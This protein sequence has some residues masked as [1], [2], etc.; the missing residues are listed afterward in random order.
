MKLNLLVGGQYMP[1]RE[2]NNEQLRIYCKQALENFEYWTR[3]LIHEKL[4]VN[5]ISYLDYRNPNGDNLIKKCIRED[6][7]ERMS[8]NPGRYSR[9]VDAFLMNDIISVLCNPT[10]YQ[11]YFQDA[12]NVA[13]PEGLEEARTFLNRLIIPRNHLSH[14][15]P[16]SIRQA[17]QILCYTNDVIDS[18][19]D[20][21]LKENSSVEYNVPQ[22]IRITDSFGNERYRDS[23]IDAKGAN[24]VVC[25][26]D[27]NSSNYLRPGDKFRIDIQIDPTFNKDEYDIVWFIA[28]FKTEEFNSKPYLFFEV[29]NSHVSERLVILCTITSNKTWHKYKNIDDSLVICLKVL[30]PL[31]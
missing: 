8:K 7:H 20:F 10:L 29:N 13:F 18:L 9:P 2:V 31:D 14:A 3:R 15:N 16:I 28:D 4:S 17:E 24:S 1:L 25:L 27:N 30:P 11:A 21:Y 23:F 19:K 22:I 12:L 6:V 26:L 5:G